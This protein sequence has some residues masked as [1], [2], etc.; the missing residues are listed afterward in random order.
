MHNNVSYW[1]TT[2]AL[3]LRGNVEMELNKSRRSHPRAIINIP[4]KQMTS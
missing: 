2:A 1:E 4:S 3:V